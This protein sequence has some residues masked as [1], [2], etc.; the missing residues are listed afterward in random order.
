MYWIHNNKSLPLSAMIQRYV[1]GAIPLFQRFHHVT[2]FFVLQ[3]YY[4]HYL[5]STSGI[6]RNLQSTS[7]TGATVLTS[8]LRDSV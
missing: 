3:L 1:V 4:C 2:F 7:I 8:Y 5:L 6:I